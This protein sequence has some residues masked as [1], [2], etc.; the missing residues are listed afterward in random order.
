MRALNRALLV[1]QLLLDRASTTIVDAVDQV[2]GLQTQYAPSAYVGLWTRL[3]GFQ[4][5][6]LTAALQD[7]SVIQAT[8]MRATIHVVS[9]REFWLYAAGVRQ[10][11][12]TWS[13]RAQGATTNEGAMVADPA[14]KSPTA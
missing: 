4:R 5:N 2:G 12:R 11:R 7:R 1:R 9:R 8:L 13:L 3:A 6:A 14:D 10:P